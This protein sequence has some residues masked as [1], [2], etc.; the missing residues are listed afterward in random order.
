MASAEESLVYVLSE[1]VRGVTRLDCL[2]ENQMEA[3]PTNV[4]CADPIDTSDSEES[5]LEE[6]TELVGD[7]HNVI[8]DERGEDQPCPVRRAADSVMDPPAE[9]VASAPK[10]G[11]CRT[12][13][14]AGSRVG[15]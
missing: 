13:Y 14:R 5:A 2:A 4:A 7:L 12:P 3:S 6:D 9:A 8:L 10:P 15:R 1:V 11:R